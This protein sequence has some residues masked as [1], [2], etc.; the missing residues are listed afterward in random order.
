MSS[1][2]WTRRHWKMSQRR[3][4]SSHVWKPFE[5]KH[6]LNIVGW[7]PDAHTQNLAHSSNVKKCEQSTVGLLPS[8]HG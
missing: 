1:G 7:K 2:S 6:E 5:Q 3:H 8:T 4:V